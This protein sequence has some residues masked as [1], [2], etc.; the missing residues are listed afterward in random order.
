MLG[1][2]WHHTF[3]FPFPQLYRWKHNPMINSPTPI[4]GSKGT[5]QL[6]TRTFKAATDLE[7]YDTERDSIYEYRKLEVNL[8]KAALVL[9]DVWS[10]HP[11]EGWTERARQ[12]TQDSI[13]PLVRLARQNSMII[14]HAPHG[15][16]IADSVKPQEDEINLD[17]T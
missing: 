2:Y 10:K 1:A 12:N 5:I 17:K 7:A 4:S 13:L 9:I 8:T 14:F 16:S 3:V 15:R 11:N 6:N